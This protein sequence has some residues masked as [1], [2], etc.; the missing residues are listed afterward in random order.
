MRLCAIHVTALWSSLLGHPGTR[1][2]D[3][4]HA[5]RGRT[6]ADPGSLDAPPCICSAFRAP[7]S[8]EEAARAGAKAAAK[9]PEIVAAVSDGFDKVLLCLDGEGGWRR[10]LDA[11]HSEAQAKWPRAAWAPLGRVVAE[12]CAIGGGDSRCWKVSPPP[13][14]AG[15]SLPLGLD[16]AEGTPCGLDLAGKRPA[17]RDVLTTVARWW[18]IRR[19][20]LAQEGGDDGFRDADATDDRRPGERQPSERGDNRSHGHAQRHDAGDPRQPVQRGAAADDAL[21]PAGSAV[22]EAARQA[23]D[24]ADRLRIVSGRSS[25][26]G[27][28][29]AAAGIEVVR[30]VDYVL[31]PPDAAG[32][33]AGRWVPSPPVTAAATDRSLGFDPRLV[34]EVRALESLKGIGHATAVALICGGQLQAG[35]PREVSVRARGSALLVVQDA[36]AVADGGK[37]A[38]VTA[39]QLASLRAAAAHGGAGILRALALAG[40]RSDVAMDVG[41][42]VAQ[43]GGEDERQDQGGD[44]SA[45]DGAE[46]QRGGAE[47]AGARPDERG[48]NLRGGDAGDRGGGSVR[49]A[50]PAAE[51]KAPRHVAE[52]APRA[53][54]PLPAFDP[55]LAASVCASC[56]VRWGHTH[57]DDCERQGYVEAPDGFYRCPCGPCAEPPRA[58]CPPAETLTQQ[59]HALDE[60]HRVP[61]RCPA[62]GGSGRVPMSDNHADGSER[63][64]R[65]DG[66]AELPP[67]PAAPTPPRGAQA[68]PS[69]TATP[70]RTTSSPGATMTDSNHSDTRMHEP[71]Y[72]ERTGEEQRPA[73]PLAIRTEQPVALARPIVQA[74]AEKGPPAMMSDDTNALWTALF[75]AQAG[76]EE[77]KKT[78]AMTVRGEIRYHY[79]N[80]SDVVNAVMPSLKANGFVCVHICRG[81]RLHVRLVHTPSGQW[82]EGVLPFVPPTVNGPEGVQALGSLLTYLRRY[83]LSMLL[84]VVAVDDDD[85]DGNSAM[86]QPQRRAS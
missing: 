51:A 45:R 10:E 7:N 55:R 66:E 62:C 26:L 38:G 74:P 28:A 22:P 3:C 17:A 71:T 31:G 63:C 57:A 19:A 36:A 40:T 68:P 33:R 21:L 73:A 43:R 56:G 65:C 18:T 39:P 75:T 59:L 34:A 8:E 72:D 25:L 41:A 60:S 64:N 13:Y 85:D 44:R 53:A 54:E 30:E 16:P 78:R 11:A 61:W 79:A 52:Q 86:Q 42:L 37:L 4:G 81:N 14:P 47:T 24:V 48:G 6:C 83:L 2:R 35:T 84:G 82:I 12:L 50:A 67:P 23:A 32:H 80:L 46:A 15:V 49:G 29:D 5:H 9:L 69:S 27:L 70:S 20:S 1:C 76:F 77:V 58:A